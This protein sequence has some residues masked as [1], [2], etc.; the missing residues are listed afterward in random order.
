MWTK[1]KNKIRLVL[2]RHGETASNKEHRYLGRTDEDLS[3][4]GAE[5]IKK[6]V[7]EKLYPEI[8]IL[9]TSPMKRCLQTA[10]LIYPDMTAHIIPEFAEMD[11]GEF[12]GKNYQDLKEDVRYQAWIDSNGTLPFPGGESRDEY[13]DR[14][15]L[16]FEMMINELYKQKS[17]SLQSTTLQSIES[18]D[19]VV[20]LMK[21]V[22]LPQHAKVNQPTIGVI[23][24]GGTI[25][26]LMHAYAGGEYFDYQVKNGRGYICTLDCSTDQIDHSCSTDERTTEAICFSNTIKL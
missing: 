6:A 21:N 4:C 3:S 9:F 22:K 13:I 23:V 11:F 7:Q 17:V 8:D 15:K 18:K 16:G 26:S 1:A 25:M 14:C 19:S 20:E 24:H 10:Q 5:K 12:E 2:I